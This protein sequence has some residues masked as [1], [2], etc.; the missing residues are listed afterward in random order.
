MSRTV[1]FPQQHPGHPGTAQFSV[2]ADP[3]RN[4]PLG[5]GH[6]W[7]C[8]KQQKL[9]PV[10]IETLWQRAGAY[11]FRRPKRTTRPQTWCTLHS[12]GQ[13]KIVLEDDAFDPSDI[14]QKVFDWAREAYLHEDTQRAIQIVAKSLPQLESAFAQQST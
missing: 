3:I 11:P 10:I 8:G 2:D 7:R 13:S 4:R 9:Q 5:V 12:A 6:G 1:F 14:A